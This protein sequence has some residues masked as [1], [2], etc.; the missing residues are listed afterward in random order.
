MR[1]ILTIVLLLATTDVSAQTPKPAETHTVKIGE[2][3]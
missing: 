3:S 1:T 2:H